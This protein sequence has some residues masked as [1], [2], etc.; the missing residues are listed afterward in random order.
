MALATLVYYRS[1]TIALGLL[2]TPAQTARF[3][4]ASTVAFGLLSFSNAVTTGLLPRLAGARTGDQAA[5][6]RRALV[7]MTGGAAVLAAL[8]AALARPLL[9]VLF[10]ARY[11]PAA[12]LLG[13]LALATVLIAPAGV[14]GTAL[15]AAHRLWPVALQVAL[16][17]AVNLVTLAVFVPR[18][19]ADGA[20][21]ATLACEAVGLILLAWLSVRCLPELV[22]R[23]PAG[24]ARVLQVE[25]VHQ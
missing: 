24:M 25:G 3:A 14:L 1:A 9:V 2:S 7:W 15:V 18:L 21:A 6:T 22:G 8:V 23:A 11:A 17:L 19:G 10:G 12:G 5:V 13:L 4:A 16:S 20:A